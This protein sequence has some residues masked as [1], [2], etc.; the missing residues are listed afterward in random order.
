M[1][2]IIAFLRTL[3][4]GYRGGDAVTPSRVGLAVQPRGQNCA[5][6]RNHDGS[7][8]QFCPPYGVSPDMIRI[9]ETLY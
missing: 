6:P 3:T 8:R 5:A 9:L 7:A 4:D 1:D 2:D